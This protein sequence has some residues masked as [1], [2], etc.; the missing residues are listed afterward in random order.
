MLVSKMARKHVTMTLSGDG[1]DEL[2]LGY[3]AYKWA[4]RFESGW[5]RYYRK[6]MR[7][8]FEE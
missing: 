7:Y 6:P 2:F 3:G 1:G 4:E 8:A 5:F